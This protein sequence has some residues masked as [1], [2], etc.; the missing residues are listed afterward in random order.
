MRARASRR[1]TCCVRVSARARGGSV[2]TVRPSVG[3]SA[4]A[5][6]AAA[7][8]CRAAQNHN[9]NYVSEYSGRSRHSRRL[10]APPP[11]PTGTT[12]T[13][14]VFPYPSKRCGNRTRN[15]GQEVNRLAY[16]SS[17]LDKT[18]KKNNTYNWAG[19]GFRSIPRF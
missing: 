9:N 13:S 19:V 4:A 8:L 3:P 14:G 1:I 12:T 7:A 5:A 6:A 2:T 10:S 11:P 16:L 17:D 18:I 15:R